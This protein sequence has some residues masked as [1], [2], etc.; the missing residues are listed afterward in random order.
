[1][2]ELEI[3]YILSI[4]TQLLNDRFRIRTYLSDPRASQEV[5]L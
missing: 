1:M 3:S 2:H 5:Q 4:V